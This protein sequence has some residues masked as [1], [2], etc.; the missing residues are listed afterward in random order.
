MFLDAKTLLG[1]LIGSDAERKIQ[2]LSARLMDVEAHAS[3]A[4]AATPDSASERADAAI[5]RVLAGRADRVRVQTGR[6]YLSHRQVKIERRAPAGLVQA[7][8]RGRDYAQPPGLRRDVAGWLHAHQRPIGERTSRT[9]GW[10]R[11]RSL[12]TG[13]GVLFVETASSSRRRCPTLK[14][15]EAR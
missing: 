8:D 14:R 3:N 11:A 9:I 12:R 7:E 5:L 15:F 10:R 13:T 6:P 1:K 2:A 4:K